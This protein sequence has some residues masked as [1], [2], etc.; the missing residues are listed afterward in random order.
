VRGVGVGV[1]RVREDLDLDG[2]KTIFEGREEW[3]T[4]GSTKLELEIGGL[5]KLSKMIVI[6]IVI[7]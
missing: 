1:V 5:D 4:S 7:G 2:R 6:V 3:K